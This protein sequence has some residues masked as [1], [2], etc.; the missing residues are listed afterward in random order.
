V[1]THIK[2]LRHKLGPGGDLIE[3][4]RGVGYRLMDLNSGPKR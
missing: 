2:R 1:D 4:I 3:T